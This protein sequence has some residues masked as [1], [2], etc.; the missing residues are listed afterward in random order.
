MI[1]NLRKKMKKKKKSKKPKIN[2]PKDKIKLAILV[3]LSLDYVY[4]DW[5]IGYIN[6]HKPE[7]PH[8]VYIICN[9]DQPLD[10]N[11]NRLTMMA[12][13]WGATHLLWLDADIVLPPDGLMKMIKHNMPVVGALCFQKVSPYRPVI[14]LKSPKYKNVHVFCEDYPKG[15]MEVH[16]TGTGAL[17]VKSEVVKNIEYPWFRFRD[18]ELHPGKMLGE[19]LYFCERAQEAGYRIYVDTK[20]IAKHLRTEGYTE[21]HWLNEKKKVHKPKKIEVY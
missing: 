1:R 11:R 21:T 18:D 19:D 10:H 7:P 17:L 3:P 8:E 16:R 4:K 14:Y 9:N 5:F 20:I 13:E 6:L 12:I 15:L 2:E